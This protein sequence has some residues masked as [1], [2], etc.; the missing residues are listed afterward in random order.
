MGSQ[1]LRYRITGSLWESLLVYVKAK[2][3][4]RVEAYGPFG[5]VNQIILFFSG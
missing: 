4:V 5:G 2:Q 3:W 1:S